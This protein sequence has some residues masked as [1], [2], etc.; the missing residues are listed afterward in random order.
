MG[1]KAT[2]RAPISHVVHIMHFI[3]TFSMLA[4]CYRLRTSAEMKSSFNTFDIERSVPAIWYATYNKENKSTGGAFEL[5][6][7]VTIKYSQII[8]QCKS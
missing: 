6:T 8:V 3:V 2:A 5:P 4:C 1:F 7:Q